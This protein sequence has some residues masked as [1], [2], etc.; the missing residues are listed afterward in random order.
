MKKIT[1][2]LELCKFDG[3]SCTAVYVGGM[4]NEMRR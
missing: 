2:D 3:A 1:E 4:N